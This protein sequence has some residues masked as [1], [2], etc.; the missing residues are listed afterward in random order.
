MLFSWIFQLMP[1]IA[2]IALRCEKVRIHRKLQWKSCLDICNSVMPAWQLKYLFYGN[3]GLRASISI[4]YYSWNGIVWEGYA[5]HTRKVI[6]KQTL[7]I[8]T[9]NHIS[10]LTQAREGAN[11]T[12]QIQKQVTKCTQHMRHLGV[13]NHSHVYSKAKNSSRCSTCTFCLKNEL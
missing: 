3:T 5:Q 11:A 8:Y 4:E 9:D 2:E 7:W 12:Q 1:F 6:L 10:G 13:L